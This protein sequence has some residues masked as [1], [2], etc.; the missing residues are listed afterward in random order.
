MSLVQDPVL[1]I[2]VY[3]L[4]KFVNLTQNLSI[5]NFEILSFNVDFLGSFKCVDVFVD[6]M[7]GCRQSTYIKLY[8]SLVLPI[9]EYGSS[10]SLE[11]ITECCS[12][13]FS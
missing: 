8:S 3:S 10:V 4:F 13:F 1:S 12:E 9:I 2:N 7:R 6:G 11:A 5:S